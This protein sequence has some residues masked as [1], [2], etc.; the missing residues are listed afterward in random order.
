ML[1]ESFLIENRM[2]LRAAY[3]NPCI[4]FKLNIYMWHLLNVEFYP[5]LLYI[6]LFLT[7]RSEL[8]LLLAY[9]YICDRTDIFG[10]ATKVS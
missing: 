2:L 9:F 6:S 10:T 8:G 1:E 3:V 5:I 7:F 4:E